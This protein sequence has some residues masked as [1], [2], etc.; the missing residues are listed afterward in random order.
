MSSVCVRGRI[1]GRIENAFSVV[2]VFKEMRQDL[3]R[4]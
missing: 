1:F 3:G 2:Q 4:N